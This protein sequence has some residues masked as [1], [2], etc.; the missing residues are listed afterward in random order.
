MLL[1]PSLSRTPANANC[2]A[3]AWDCTRVRLDG[4]V[5]QRAA[6][7][8][9]CN[10]LR[11]CAGQGANAGMTVEEEKLAGWGGVALQAIYLAPFTVSPTEAE[12]G[13]L[14]QGNAGTASRLKLMAAQRDKRQMFM[15]V[16]VVAYAALVGLWLF[17]KSPLIQQLSEQLL[18]CSLTKLQDFLFTFVER[19]TPLV[20]A[21]IVWFFSAHFSFCL[22]LK[23]SFHA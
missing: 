21:S 20:V 4:R 5:M 8:A 6:R 1:T 17:S 11:T 13:I 10:L 15:V 7:P 23:R 18:H 12:I 2:S 14:S 19:V 3:A 16:N 9:H 22:T